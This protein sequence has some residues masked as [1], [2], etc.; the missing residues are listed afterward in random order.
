MNAVLQSRVC[1]KLKNS[2]KQEC[3]EHGEFKSVSIDATFK[4]CFAILGQAKFN[5]HKRIR[6]KM[7]IKDE[8]AKYRILTVR[9]I[10]SAVLATELV[11]DESGVE[12]RM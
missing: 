7:A 3:Y 10:T 2:L 4:I 5:R 6:K 8:D 11:H 1:D 9:G 12:V